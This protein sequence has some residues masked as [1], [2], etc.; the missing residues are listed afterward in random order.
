MDSMGVT[1]Q[2]GSG[3]APATVNQ[4]F[5]FSATITAGQSVTWSIPTTSIEPHTI[6]W[7]PAYGQDVSPIPV[8]GGT[9]ILALGASIAPMTNSG[10]SIGQEGTFQS[11]LLLPGQSFSLTFTE[12]G[13]YPYTCA[14]H[15]GMTGTITVLP[16]E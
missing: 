14:I 2:A 12:P 15:P 1:I 9:P 8:E 10:S 7:P 13:V 16:A 4:F 3:P 6:T 5:P 11:G